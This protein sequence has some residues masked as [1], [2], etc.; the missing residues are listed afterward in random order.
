[1]KKRLEDDLREELRNLERRAAA[2]RT[3]LGEE[4]AE[5]IATLQNIV[6]EMRAR[7]LHAAALRSCSISQAVKYAL[8]QNGRPMSPLEIREWLQENGYGYENKKTPLSDRIRGEL[9]TMVKHGL[10]PRAGSDG[11]YRL[12]AG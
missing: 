5:P 12:S 4:Q 2:I 6:A 10:L 11:R 7:N 3:L 1:M 8:E 9:H